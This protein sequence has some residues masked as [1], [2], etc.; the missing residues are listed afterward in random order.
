MDDVTNPLGGTSGSRSN[1]V[2]RA[3]N[4]LLNPNQEWPRIEAERGTIREILVRYVLPLAVIGPI[5][6]FIGSQVFGFGALGITFRPSLMSA[7][8]TAIVTY[9]LTV[10]GIFALS[11]IADFLS[12]KFDGTSNRLSAFKLVAYSYT[13]MM[14]AGVFGIIPNL[15][16]LGLLGF[17]SVYLF[18]RGALP[19]M[20]VP[21]DK[22]VAYTAVTVVCAIVI[23]IV[24]GAIA[25]ATVGRFVAG[26]TYMNSG[27]LSGE[28]TV[29][30]VGTIDA[31]KAQQAAAE[32]EA[33]ATGKRPAVD[34]TR[35]QALLPSSIGGYQRTSVEANA[36]GAMGSEAN[37]TYSAGDRTF[38]LK[39]TD[40]A[41]LGGLAGLGSAIGVQ[42]SREDADGYERTGT[43]DGRMQTESWSKASGTGKFGVMI[44]NRFMVQA[45]GSAA[46]I[47]ELKSAVA[48]VDE[49]SLAGLAGPAG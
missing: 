24:V 2:E 47:D 36:L 25:T 13:A 39:I 26:P 9:V 46:G 7:V 15:G 42:S 1:I 11:L 38:H 21:Q 48:T 30:G 6:S 8:S 18:Y 27:E 14:L 4:I 12:P 35:L 43:V 3:K 17:Y 28:V 29:P 33:A 20:K 49:S 32:M 19:L 16:F 10:I 37:A 41:A 34:P 23:Y 31:G 5:A 44:G 40:M 22:G 45:E